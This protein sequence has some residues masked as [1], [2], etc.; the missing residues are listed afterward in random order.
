MLINSYQQRCARAQ[1]KREVILRFLRDETWSNLTNLTSVLGLTEPA[2]FKTISQLE[3]DGFLLRHKVESLRI[4]LWGVTPQGLAFAWH[5]SETM[6]PRPYFEPSKLSVLTI[7]HY[8]DIQ[9]ARLI[10]ERAGW[11][12][13][14]P[15]TRLPKDIKKRPDAIATDSKGNIV[16]IELERTIKTLK[17]Y[18][19][20]FAIYLQLMKRD[21]YAKVH[22]V[23]P[24][25]SFAP[26]LIRMFELIKS[27][28]VAGERVPITEKHRARFPVYALDNWPPSSG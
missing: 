15:G 17:R 6:Q 14:I 9:R 7:Y 11:T 12:N 3:R 4:S 23:C 16:A 10:A 21:E 28:P 2:A 1:S 19:A 5:E 22:Y 20:I 27:V 18:E 25:A 26:R 13:W 24:D 8:L